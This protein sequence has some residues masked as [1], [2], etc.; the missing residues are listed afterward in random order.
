MGGAYRIVLDNAP[1]I[2][3]LGRLPDDDA[4]RVRAIR[5]RSLPIHPSHA[6][7]LQVATDPITG[8]GVRIRVQSLK[9]NRFF[10]TA[11]QT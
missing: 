6:A 11:N 3:F 9:F 2:R 4:P 5:L 10:P 8:S 1:R 7:E